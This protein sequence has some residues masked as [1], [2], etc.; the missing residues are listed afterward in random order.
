MRKLITRQV[1]HDHDLVTA[2]QLATLIA[3]HLGYDP[4]EQTRIATAVSEIVRNAFRYALNA[5]VSFAVDRGAQPQAFVAVVEDDGPGI[6]ELDAVLEGRYRSRTGLGIGIIGARR[7]MDDVAITT[8]SAG[9]TVIL[10]RHLSPR[11]PVV[12]ADRLE[13]LEQAI[14]TRERHGI[15][16]E[17]EHQNQELLLALQDLQRKQEELVLLNRELEDT[18]RGVVALYGEL[19]DRAEHARQADELKTRVLSNIT[20]EFRTPVNAILGLCTLLLD[21]RA[22]EAG[23]PE[24]ELG[25]I[26]AS[27]EHLR[28]L[29]DDL[30]D[31]AKVAAGK[32]VVR[33]NA[34][35][36]DSIFGA[37][38]GMLRPLLRNE[39]VSLVFDEPRDVPALETDE[40]KVSQILR[41]LISNA[42][43]FTE[44]GEVR[45]SAAAGDGG[46]TVVFKVADTGI[47]I[48]PEDHGRIF[49]EFTQLEHRLK[50]VTRGTG[51]GLPLS[52]RLAEVLG[53]SITV[54]STP[55]IGS[56]FTVRLPARYP[57]TI[58]S[59]PASVPGGDPQPLPP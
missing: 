20:H 2:R 29:V 37:L 56:T 25:F 47:G 42:L 39:S 21:K 3:G 9:T 16:D 50:R 53:G 28:G 59:G 17:I 32:T 41:N 4:S 27:A 38:R 35:T 33:V 7:L 14:R 22:R 40:A 45:V 44:R 24:P 23:E 6:A 58:T 55:G 26:M 13:A 34:F 49:D 54:S 51:L 19:D 12:T 31:L 5:R 15:L 10:R 57:P 36:V 30:L 11:A 46:R 8:G 1:R 48:A 43:K 52:R 18:N